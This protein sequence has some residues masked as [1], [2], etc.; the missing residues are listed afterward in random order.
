MKSNFCDFCDCADCKNG[1]QDLR[2]AKTADGRWICDVCYTYDVCVDAWRKQGV[3][4]G[5]CEHPCNHKPKLIG[6]WQK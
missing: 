3:R 6:G 5:P 2:H 4:L 1:R